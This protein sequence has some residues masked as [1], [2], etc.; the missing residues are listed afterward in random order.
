MQVH[1]RCLW[2][3]LTRL[4]SEQTCTSVSNN[5]QCLTPRCDYQSGQQ[6]LSSTHRP[7]NECCILRNTQSQGVNPFCLV[8]LE[9][10]QEFFAVLFIQYPIILKHTRTQKFLN[11]N[12][13]TSDILFVCFFIYFLIFIFFLVF[14]YVSTVKTKTHKNVLLE[15][16]RHRSFIT[17]ESPNNSSQ[18]TYK[19]RN[20]PPCHF[21]RLLSLTPHSLS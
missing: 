20:I 12:F 8:N 2:C 16:Q 11:V 17:L 21:Y 4:M 14:R 7:S 6:V 10:I 19:E 1:S 18:E 9:V 3:G 5:S 15:I 13:S